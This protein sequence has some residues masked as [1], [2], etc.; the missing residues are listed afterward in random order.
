MDQDTIM[1][2]NLDSLEGV[3]SRLL[4]PRTIPRID[5]QSRPTDVK[6]LIAD[7]GSRYA[8]AELSNYEIYDAKQ[9]AV[10]EDVKTFAMEMEERTKGGGG[11]LLYGG[12]GTGK[13]HVIAALLKIAIARYGFSAKWTDGRKLFADARK[14]IGDEAETEFLRKLTRPYILAISDPQPPQGDLTDFQSSLLRDVIDRRYRDCK[15]TWM[16]TNLDRKDDA[17]AMLSAPVIDRINHDVTKFFFD[18]QSYRART[19]KP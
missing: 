8:H 19:V 11:L 7:L 5:F 3:I 13:D 10:I 2:L 15:P 1:E 14:A 4:G 17:I 18:W 12:V 9:R 6:G 16:T